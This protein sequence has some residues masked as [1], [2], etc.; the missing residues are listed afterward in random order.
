MSGSLEREVG[1][2]VGLG[3]E[4]TLRRRDWRTEWK[5]LPLELVTLQLNAACLALKSPPTMNLGP[6]EDRKESKVTAETVLFGG[7]YTEEI[8][9]GKCEGD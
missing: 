9:I 6:E 4:R 8:D 2:Y 1:Q 7:Q 3:W 5:V